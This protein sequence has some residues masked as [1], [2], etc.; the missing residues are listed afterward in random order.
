VTARVL[1]RTT[2]LA[3]LP[4]LVAPASGQ[5]PSSNPDFTALEQRL[6]E[7]VQQNDRSAMEKM[8]SPEFVLRANPDVDRQTWIDNA[9]KY[10]WGDRADITDLEVRPS[11][12]MAVVTFVLTFYTNP[13]T[14]ESQT[15]GSLITDVWTAADGGWLLLVRHAAPL[16]AG[17]DV[18]QQ[19][20]AKLPEPPPLV[21]G[22]GELSFVSTGGNSETQT[23]GTRGSLIWR[24]GAW[25]TELKAG[26]VNATTDG[27]RSARSLNAEVRES[28]RLTPRTELYGHG[29]YRR[30][31]FAGIENRFSVD[32]GLAF[33]VLE[34]EPQSLKLDAGVGYV[35]EDRLDEPASRFAAATAGADYRWTINDRSALS[36]TFGF[37]AN[38]EDGNDWRYSNV[39]ALTVELNS[40]F[41]L[42]LSH[43]ANFLNEPVDGFEKLDTITSVA[44]VTTFERKAR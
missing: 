5:T 34:P 6:I 27:V 42:K 25:T 24:P 14:C 8:L 16:T 15:N 22:T 35:H 37:T 12:R 28:R 17:A 2:A 29:G 30:D 20:F 19:Q 43:A 36:D 31:L 33:L 32:G 38:L 7:V 10:C 13:V 41:A 21:E 9:L 3:L 44:L 11:G 18:I 4:W 40:T 23:L 39:L 26:F 1:I